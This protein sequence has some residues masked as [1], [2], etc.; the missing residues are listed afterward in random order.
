M[1][2]ADQI[3]VYAPEMDW[4]QIGDDIKARGMSYSQQALRLEK[5]QSTLEKWLQGAQPRFGDGAAW[6]SLH[7]KVCGPALT[8][9]RLEEAGHRA[10]G[11]NAK[12]FG[13]TTV[14]A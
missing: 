1:A 14:T 4:P 11:P 5:T 8:E 3:E 9:Q 2:F 10:V 6:L 7:T 13:L 12:A